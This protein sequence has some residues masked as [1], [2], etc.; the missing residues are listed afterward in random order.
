MYTINKTAVHQS[1]T[2]KKTIIMC[3]KIERY[4]IE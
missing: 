2:D 3:L 1:R 4:E